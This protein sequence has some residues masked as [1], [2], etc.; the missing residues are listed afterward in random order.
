M[1]LDKDLQHTGL[2][3]S[4]GGV[5]AVAFHLGVLARLAAGESLG[6]VSHISTVSGGSL[7]IALVFSL[8]KKTWPSS[9]AFLESV[10]PSAKALLT[11]HSLERAYVSNLLLS[12]WRMKRG[13][14]YIL[15]QALRG[16]WSVDGTLQDLPD[17]PRWAIN[18]T[19][20]ET[21]KRWG[22]SKKWMG[23]YRVNYV[24]EPDFSIADAVAASA[25]FP[26]PIG[27]LV[28]Q[29]ESYKWCK[30]KFRNG[31][32]EP[33]DSELAEPR[34]KRLF[35]WDGGVYENSGTEGVFRPERGYRHGLDF[36]IVSDAGAGLPEEH[37][38]FKLSFLPWEVYT[39]PSRLVNIAMDQVRSLRARQFVT[40]LRTHPQTGA[41][42]RLGN[43]NERILKDAET[44][45]GEFNF[46]ANE[47]R[48]NSENA[49]RAHSAAAF[50]TRLCRL[51]EDQ[52]DMLFQHGYEVADTTL[53]A[54]CPSKFREVPYPTLS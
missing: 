36:V 28:L 32:D 29:C 34:F 44:F 12:F 40:H 8:T 30:L 24:L 7:A 22:F 33:Y 26:G 6:K 39:P 52:F 49:S 41:Y 21:G 14:A 25:G 35:L 10:V 17:T 15:G 4:G 5:R 37:R 3:L 31:E 45:F 19:T 47:N 27:P 9:G 13:R 43:T 38:R 54:Y 18:C 46:N 48:V 42:L 53:S 50:P 16:L 51:T 1:A 11:R 2:A 23:D 20:F